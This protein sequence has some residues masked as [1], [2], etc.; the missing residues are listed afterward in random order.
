[1]LPTKGILS[2]YLITKYTIPIP[3]RMSAIVEAFCA[4]TLPISPNTPWIADI[5]LFITVL[6]PELEL[7]VV[8]VLVE[9]LMVSSS[10]VTFL[11]GLIYITN[12]NKDEF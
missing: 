7:E 1:M 12:T 2:K 10:N 4:N 3:I 8:E 6:H 5:K 11:L 9:V